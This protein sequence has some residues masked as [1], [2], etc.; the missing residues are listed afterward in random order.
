MTE[1]NMSFCSIELW[2]HASQSAEFRVQD[3]LENINE[4][5]YLFQQLE[6]VCKHE[7]TGAAAW[8]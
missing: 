1:I 3:P 6:T 7:N 2:I 4:L 8:I 5:C